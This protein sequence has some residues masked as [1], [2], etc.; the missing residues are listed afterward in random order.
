[1]CI[2]YLAL[3]D[4]PD[5]PLLIAANRDEYHARPA[6]PIGPWAGNPDVI[7]GIDLKAGGTWLG[8]TRQG[9]FGLLTNYREPGHHSSGAPS[10]GELVS[11]WLTSAND[12]PTYIRELSGQAD[13]YNGF[14]LIVGDL[15]AACYLGNRTP[16]PA[17]QMLGPGRY[18][19]SNHLLDT[20]WP[21]AERLRQ[22][23]A[24]IN[25][26]SLTR[27]LRTVFATLKDTTPADDDS[28]PD[29]GIDRELER[30]LSSPF[31]ISADYGTRCSSVIAVH[32]SGRALFSEISYDPSGREVQRHDWPFRINPAPEYSRE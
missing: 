21:K 11:A 13:A 24:Q 32:R 31:I 7:A 17:P 15:N 3:N 12:L 6:R 20:P 5:W 27:S 14:N 28:L 25:M 19:V 4:H 29:T 8:V 10:R 18:V 26:D 9:R 2:A 23:F 22:A 30:L 1:M 16:D